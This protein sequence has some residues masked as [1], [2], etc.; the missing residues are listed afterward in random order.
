MM[1]VGEH[2]GSGLAIMCD[3]LAGALT[4]GW[5][6]QPEHPQ[7]DGII[8]NML[9]VIVAPDALGEREAV[10]REIGAAVAWIKSS[11]PR[12]GFDEVLVPGE[13]ERRKRAARLAGGIEIDL[14]SWDHVR[15]AATRAGEAEAE[16][17][18]LAG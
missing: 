6:N 13:P 10:E 12:A 16:I 15:A 5:T 2:K 4:G 11:R 9:S 8:N 14:L 1:S 3:L 17:D 7:A 18:R